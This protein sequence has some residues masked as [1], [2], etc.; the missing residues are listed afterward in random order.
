M[1]DKCGTS[2]R[3]VIPYRVQVLAYESSFGRIAGGG[4][5]SPP[6]RIEL[7]TLPGRVGTTLFPEDAP[8]VGAAPGEA[9]AAAVLAYAG[10]GLQIGAYPPPGGW[11]LVRS[12]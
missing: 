9:T 4:D 8:M 11:Q 12:P 3:T 2:G 6:W 1:R 7:S 5:G 10:G